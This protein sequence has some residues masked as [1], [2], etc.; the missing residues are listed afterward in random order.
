M[1]IEWKKIEEDPERDV[2][3]VG[4]FLLDNKNKIE[5]L[6]HE[7]KSKDNEIITLQKEVFALQKG[8]ADKI[9]I[10]NK[11]RRLMLI[12]KG[13]VL[14]TYKRALGG[15]LIGPKERQGDNETPE[16]TCVID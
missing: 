13:K 16:G 3:V 1:V 14:K 6:E 11:E 2:K 10:E 12:S 7:V 8:P 15:D 5:A 9:L 4:Q